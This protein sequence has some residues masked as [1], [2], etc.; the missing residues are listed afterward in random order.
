M[1]DVTIP[2]ELLSRMNRDRELIEKELP[3]LAKRDARMK[4]A[5]DQ[6]TLCGHLRRAIHASQRPLRGL[7]AD[8]GIATGLLC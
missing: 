3:E 2:P 6:D 1:S 8:A 7:A 5:A 4:N